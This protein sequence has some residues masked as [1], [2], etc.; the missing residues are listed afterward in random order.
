MATARWPRVMLGRNDAI[1]SS[2]ERGSRSHHASKPTGVS[3]G[4]RPAARRTVD[5]LAVGRHG[6]VSTRFGLGAG[7]I[8][9]AHTHNGVALSEHIGDLGV[10]PERE[11]RLFGSSARERVDQ[12]PLRHHRDVGVPDIESFQIRENQLSAAFA[13][14]G[15]LAHPGLWKACEAFPRGRGGRG[16]AGWTGGRDAP[17]LGTPRASRRGVRSGAR[18]DRRTGHRCAAM[19][20]TP[21]QRGS[22]GRRLAP[23]GHA[24]VRAPAER[25][26]LTTA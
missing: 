24:V 15:N 4:T 23:P 25:S 14:I 5:Q 13:G 11:G 18:R 22:I 19:T 7:G 8:P 17:Q 26:G 10:H 2:A 3:R 1:A 9:V 21:S 16:T 6:Q 20:P 12:V